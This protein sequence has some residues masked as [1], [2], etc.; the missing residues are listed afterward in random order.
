MNPG[1]QVGTSGQPFPHTH[2]LSREDFRVP[3]GHAAIYTLITVVA[4]PSLVQPNNYEAIIVE[5]DLEILLTELH[6]H[7]GRSILFLNRLEFPGGVVKLHTYNFSKTINDL[8]QRHTHAFL[9]AI[10]ES[11]GSTTD[12]LSQV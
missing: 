9:F 3:T 1:S 11:Q 6:R 10:D 2:T 8:L 7:G 4:T 5:R 12:L